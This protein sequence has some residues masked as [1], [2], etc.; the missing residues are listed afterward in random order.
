MANRI[1]AEPFYL[2]ASLIFLAAILHTF[3]TSKFLAFAHRLHHEYEHS[4]EEGHPKENK[5]FLAEVMHFVG[6]VEAVFGMWVVVLAIA[7]VIFHGPSTLIHYFSHVNYVEPMFVVVIMSLAS[8]RPVVKLA[9]MM[10]E[11]I[12]NVMGGTLTAW[13]FTILI[14]GPLLGSFITEPAAMTISALLLAKKFYSLGPSSKFSYATIG[15]LFVN[16]SVG[17]TLSH[18]AAPPVLMV[19]APWDWGLVFMITSFGWKAAVGIVIATGVY[20]VFNKSEMAE[21]EKKYAGIEAERHLE[22][23]G[24]DRDDLENELSQMENIV[25]KELGFNDT[26]EKKY[27]EIKTRLKSNLADKFQKSPKLE[28]AFERLFAEIKRKEIQKALPGLLPKEER[29]PYRD[30]DWDER[31][32]SVPG[33][34]MLVHVLFMAWTVFY[35]HYP[36]LF[37]G[38]F[39]FFLG[40]AQATSP[41]QNRTDLKPS[42]LVG[43]FLAGLVTHGGLQAWWIAPVLGSLSE[44]PLML[45]AT[46]LTAFNDNA[47]ITYLSTLVPGFTDGMK[48]AVVAGAVTG[49]GLTVIANAPNPAGQS[50]LAKY[51]KNGV[52]PAG[53]A[54]GALIPTIILG[55]CFMLLRF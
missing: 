12:A 47:A 31:S 52:S 55:L 50:I 27:A 5:R 48:Y 9:E 29:P 15:L 11:K 10:M 25:S 2:V 33:W 13:W 21:L 30:P 19:A 37:I 36:P 35:A 34:V 4:V 17:G 44:V 41:Y 3:I 23:T 18:F 40:F 20:Y 39:L 1:A 14:F 53:L 49:G 16:V 54:K 28:P 32:D 7:F 38:G 45:G 42:L 26:I 22:Q 51:F 43:F 46:I 6:E 24:I 8:T